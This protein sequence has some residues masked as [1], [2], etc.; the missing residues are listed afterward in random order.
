MD[1]QP[2]GKNKGK[3]TTKKQEVFRKCGEND[4]TRPV[5]NATGRRKRA[6]RNS[7]YCVRGNDNRTFVD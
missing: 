5:P 2:K 4:T 7:P 1:K 6:Q 3:R